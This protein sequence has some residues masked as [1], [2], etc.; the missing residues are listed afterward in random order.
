MHAGLSTVQGVAKYDRLFEH[1]CDAGDGPLQMAFAA[2]GALVGS[3]PKSAFTHSAWWANEV[4]GRHVQAAAWTNAGRVVEHAD[5]S[6]Q[7]A[8][9]SAELDVMKGLKAKPGPDEACGSTTIDGP[10]GER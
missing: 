9:F 5:L 7:I 10:S 8:K 3:P 2:V 1:L 6:R 4:D